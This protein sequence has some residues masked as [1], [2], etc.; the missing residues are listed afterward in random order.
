[1]SSESHMSTA[2]RVFFVRAT[3]DG[4]WTL[5]EDGDAQPQCFGTKS[6]AVEA[7]KAL[8][9]GYGPAQLRVHDAGG[10]VEA[11]LDYERDPLVTQLKEFGF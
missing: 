7:G 3:H 11:E 4:G 8:A 9:Q 6:A 5:S 2:T 1:M 10:T